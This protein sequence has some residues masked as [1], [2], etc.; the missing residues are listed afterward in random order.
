MTLLRGQSVTSTKNGNKTIKNQDAPEPI[1]LIQTLCHRILRKARGVS[2][3][4]ACRAC[5]CIASVTRHLPGGAV[6]VSCP[7]DSAHQICT[8]LC[9]LTAPS[10]ET[11]IPPHRSHRS[12]HSSSNLAYTHLTLKWS[13]LIFRLWHFQGDIL[14]TSNYFFS[15]H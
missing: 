11:L 15:I 6:V 5:S 10:S 4:A 13:V 9:L 12:P 8:H 14:A 2:Q 7:Q 1:Q 3:G